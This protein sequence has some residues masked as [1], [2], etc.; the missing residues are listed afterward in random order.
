MTKNG[1][2]RKKIDIPEDIMDRVILAIE[3]LQSELFLK[4]C[5]IRVNETTFSDMFSREELLKFCFNSHN[6]VADKRTAL[7]SIQLSKALYKDY[8]AWRDDLEATSKQIS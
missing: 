2:I 5:Q 7:N 1:G 8:V 4:V 6:I 3:K